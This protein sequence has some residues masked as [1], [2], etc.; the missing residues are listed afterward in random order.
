MEGR[1][2]A[3]LRIRAIETQKQVSYRL[4]HS[5]REQASPPVLFAVVKHM[6]ALAKGLQISQ[7]V[8]GGIMVKVRGRQHYPG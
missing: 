3:L 5:Q 4:P 1:E 6:A 7:P 8:I 2:R